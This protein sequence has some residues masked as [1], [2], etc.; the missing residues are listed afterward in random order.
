MKEKVQSIAKS[1]SSWSSNIFPMIVDASRKRA[2][3]VSRFCFYQPFLASVSELWGWGGTSVVE[4]SLNGVFRVVRRVR[5]S[6]DGGVRNKSGSARVVG[7]G[8]RSASDIAFAA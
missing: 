7:V 6:G 2:G 4:S 8:V 1:T 5:S 3:S